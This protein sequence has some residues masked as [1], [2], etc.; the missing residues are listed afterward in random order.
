LSAAVPQVAAVGPLP[1]VVGVVGHRYLSHADY[2]I[3]RARIEALFVQLRADFPATPLRVISA[4]AEGAD[5]LV[6]EVALQ[7]G[8]DLVVPL[9]MPPEDYEQDFPDSVAEFRDLMSRAP[10][11]NVFVLP[12]PHP[13]GS[14]PTKADRDARYLEAGIYTAAQSHVVLALWDGVR[15]DAI[16]GTAEVVRF[17]LEGHLH[18]DDRALSSDDRGPVYCIHAPRSGSGDSANVPAQWLYPADSDQAL[19]RTVCQRME[20]FNGDAIRG[21]TR[22]AVAESAASLVPE[23][24]SRPRAD[25]LLAEAFAHADVLARR[26]QRLTHGVLR[27]IIGLTVAL[28]LTF[29]IYAEIMSRRELPALYLIIFSA[30][31]GLYLWHKRFDAQG[32]YLD[33]RALAEA[34]RVQF[35]WRLGGLTDSAAASYLRKQL[36]ELRWIRD[37]LRG[38]NTLPP[39]TEAR[40]D[41]VLQHWVQGQSSYYRDRAGRQ[42]RRIHRI[43]RMSE[44]CLGIGLL[45][46]T[47]LLV[48]WDHLEVWGH[49]RHW[50]VLVMGFAPIAAA[51]WEVY[52]ER[53]GLRSQAHQYARF[54]A[55]FTRAEKTLL[56][57]HAASAATHRDQN[58]R[59]LVRELGREALMESGDWVLSLRERPIA[60]PKG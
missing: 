19:F 23:L 1:L 33:Y 50:L 16:A 2:P 57:A 47:C 31:A 44:V 52:G 22:A 28:A 9:P 6:A 45:A 25:R 18:S 3:Y 30:I 41:L 5:R 14:T 59:A 55:I 21:D 32:R 53:F 10:A 15:N 4:L 43:E 40:M 58:E 29:E 42:S 7:N 17:K 11:G 34:L 37:A 20:R 38:T 51:L 49:W 39:P 54:A 24:A 8:C 27:T 12:A 56:Q 35:Y 36:D 26:Y 13:A 46:T 60:L 48:L